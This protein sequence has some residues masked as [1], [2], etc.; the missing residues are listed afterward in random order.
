MILRDSPWKVS[1]AFPP[2]HCGM[3]APELL[4]PQSFGPVGP[5]VDLYSLGIAAIE[6]LVGGNL[7][8]HVKGVAGE[9]EELNL[10]WM[11]WHSSSNEQVP[12]VRELVAN[13]PDD[14]AI[15]IDGLTR[16]KPDQRYRSAQE[17]IN[18]LV[19]KPI[20]LIDPNVTGR[21]RSFLDAVAKNSASLGSVNQ[22]IKGN[23]G[24]PES[25]S[26]GIQK[27]VEWTRQHVAL[28]ATLGLLALLLILT[29][30]SGSKPTPAAVK[31]DPKE[32]RSLVKII[33]GPPAI[34]RIDEG[35]AIATPVEL[36]LPP[37]AYQ[38]DL[39]SEGYKSISTQIEV[40]EKSNTF[41]FTLLPIQ[42]PPLSTSLVDIVSL[43][44]G[45]S[46]K[47]DGVDQGATP[48]TVQLQFGEHQIEASKA[49]CVTQRISAFVDQSTRTLEI[50]LEE[51]LVP[52]MVNMKSMPEGASVTVDGLLQGVTPLATELIPGKH[53]VEV[54]LQG[55][56]L[57]RKT[58]TVDSETDEFDFELQPLLG[59]VDA[60]IPNPDSYKN[61]TEALRKLAVLGELPQ[62]IDIL[63]TDMTREQ[64]HRFVAHFKSMLNENWA[65]ATLRDLALTIII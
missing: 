60:S 48:R 15:V 61:D 2:V 44:G 31:D 1:F 34:A 16:K 36:E 57:Q 23:S 51:E 11:R 56:H 42:S 25:P 59:T 6:M 18:D 5:G 50:Q 22:S 55:H 19:D 65:H 62:Q 63:G 30:F 46:I 4:K 40:L 54:V 17:A 29:V 9:G 20:V 41:E 58:I 47:V 3:Y 49:G 24:G 28:T 45:A 33:T 64:K 27:A 53:E 26:L 43:P 21:S 38:L 39:E 8:K 12:S 37:G 32:L 14:L 35:E 13:V 7:Q 52:R 10:S